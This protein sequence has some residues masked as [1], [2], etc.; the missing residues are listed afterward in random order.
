MSSKST[1]TQ[2]NKPYEP[3]Q[4][5]IDQGLRDAK[6]LYDRGG[7]DITPYDGKMVADYGTLGERAL[8]DTWSTTRGN[9]DSIKSAQDAAVAAMDPTVSDAVKSNVIAG[10]M[11]SINSSFAKSGMTGSDLHSQNLSKGLSAGLADVEDQARQRA[12][13]AAGMLPGLGQ[14]A[15]A[16][17]D[18][19]DQM[20][21]R[22]RDY[23][24]TKINANMMRDQQM[25][26]ADIDALQNYLA[27]TT[28]AGSM[29]GVQSA[30]SKQGMG[31]LGILGAGLQF[32]PFMAGL[33]DRRAKED[34]R[35]VGQTDD[36]LPIYVYRYKGGDQ[37]MMG[38]M[39]DEVEAVQP[40]AV[41]T[42]PD[43]LKAVH[44]ERIGL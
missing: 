13:M 12:L 27:L 18:F 38:V 15:N 34:I 32:A 28:G 44:Y 16:Q 43:G 1:T 11:P 6:S 22:Y 37:F 14:A 17:N 7:F 24:Q 23:Q 39:A 41:M 40:E 35:R 19:A 20:G 33:S 10:I 36:G 25:K 31:P 8:R 30:T 9:L 5:L 42:R 26:T 2:N 21:K 29:F 4:P 3:A